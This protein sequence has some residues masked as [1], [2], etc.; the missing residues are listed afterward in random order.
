MYLEISLVFLS[1]AVFLIAAVTVPLLFQ[2]LKMFRELS[3]A[4][5]LL[6][7]RLPVILQNLE[8]ASVNAKRITIQVNDQVERFSL[9]VEKIQAMFHLIAEFEKV[10][11]IGA[12]IPLFNI[13]RSVGALTKGIRVFLNVYATGRR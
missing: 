8:E 2:I 13:I 11:H 9:G 4:L 5:E 12:R 10:L 6:Q 7:K 1:A 3:L